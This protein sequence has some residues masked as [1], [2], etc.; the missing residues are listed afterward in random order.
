M[1]WVLAGV[2]LVTL[3]IFSH[4]DDWGRDLTTNFAR[5]DAESDDLRPARIALPM[6]PAA[7]LV[8]RAAGKLPGWE[9]AEPQPQPLDD[10]SQEWHF[11]RT[12]RLMRYKDDVHVRLEPTAD[13]SG[14]IA[15]IRSRSR[16]GK[17]DLGQNPRNIR[18]LLARIEAESTGS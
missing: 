2:V 7:E 16:I 9:L 15:H 11:V 17:G 8:R 4:I 6:E 1:W 12:T 13:G 5:T 10:G 3:Y 14:V 18:E